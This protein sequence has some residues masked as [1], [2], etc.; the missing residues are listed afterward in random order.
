MS[1]RFGFT[2]IDQ[3]RPDNLSVI[4]SWAIKW[5]NLC[6]YV[7]SQNIDLE[8]K[9][10]EYGK[11]HLVMHFLL[12]YFLYGFFGLVLVILLFNTLS[13][14]SSSS[15]AACRFIQDGSGPQGTDS[16]KL[17]K[18]ISGLEVPW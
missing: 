10:H 7:E 15:G 8:D 16:V 9:R 2:Q 14:T 11:A 17:E 12:K 1:G 3:F 18:V 5:I 13:P 4:H 6:I